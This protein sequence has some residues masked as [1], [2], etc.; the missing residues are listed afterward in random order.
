VNTRAIVV[1]CLFAVLMIA[2]YGLPRCT[3]R[4]ATPNLLSL[5][6]PGLAE[7]I[8]LGT[9]HGRHQQNPRY[10]PQVLRDLIVRLKPAVILVELPSTIEGKPTIV[11]RQI[12]AWLAQNENWS[13]NAAAEALQVPIL[14]YDR[15]GRN[16]FYKE[17][18]YFERQQQ[19]SR[20]VESWLEDAE[21]HNSDPVET[22]IAGTL[23]DNAEQSQR[24]FDLNAGPEIINSEGYD[25]NIR[26]KHLIYRNIVPQ[27]APRIPSLSS[28]AAEFTYFREEW[29][30][31]NAIMADNIAREARK[32]PTQRI[33]VLCG[34]EHRYILRDLLAKQSDILLKEFYEVDA[35]KGPVPDGR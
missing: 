33:A 4:E 14:P 13:A 25:R 15:E 21:Q 5:A 18:K 23:Y 35:K 20:R 32:H 6:D 24:Y 26:N 28:L 29:Q 2:A 17:T 34:S 8:L 22:A 7:V 19:L 31:R 1:P 16:E 11:D 10:S 3:A 27:F 30:E 12:A 9:I